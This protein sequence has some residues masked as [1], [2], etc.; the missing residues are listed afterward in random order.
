MPAMRAPTPMLHR[1]VAAHSPR[2]ARS[3]TRVRSPSAISR[4]SVLPTGLGSRRGPALRR[5]ATSA[6]ATRKVSASAA[7][8]V[9][10]PTTSSSGTTG[11]PSRPPATRWPVIRRA[12]ALPSA[13]RSTSAGSSAVA[14]LSKRVWRVVRAKARAINR[15]I[16]ACPRATATAKQATS[17]PRTASTV[18]MARRWSTRSATAPPSSPKT[19]QGR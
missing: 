19:I 11:A 3:R 17:S 4:R 1:A 7:K 10:T 6:A 16:E 18:H 14:A 15:P 12:F 2:R 5:D 8:G 9:A 13:A